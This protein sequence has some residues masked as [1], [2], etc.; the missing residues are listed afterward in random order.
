MEIAA[1]RGVVQPAGVSALHQARKQFTHPL[2]VFLRIHSVSPDASDPHQEPPV[3]GI[4]QARR[5]YPLRR[6]EARDLA[7]TDRKRRQALQSATI[8]HDLTAHYGSDGIVERLLGALDGAGFDIDALEPEALAGADEFHIGGRVGSELVADALAVGTGDHVLDIGSGIGGTARF[9][10]RVTG[11]KVSGVDLTPEFVDAAIR[12]TDLV[13]LFDGIDFRTGSATDLPFDN[14]SF[15]AICMVHVGMNIA[16][17][18]AMFTEMARVARPD[19]P[20]VVYDIMLTG[21]GDELVYPM[22]W[23]STP[24]FSFPALQSEYEAA[25]AAAGLTLP[26][27]QDHS[28]LARKFFNEPPA[29]PPQVTLGHLMGPEMPT[30]FSNAKAAVNAGQISPVILTFRT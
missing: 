10:R 13:G 16:D 2:Q 29:N 1:R 14:A 5:I 8:T 11:A 7:A 17:K 19:S 25:A 18:C 26:A 24:E 6:W 21:S 30:M 15:D 9:L 28:D 20:A 27:S 22:P 3:V 4:T 23:S 12:L